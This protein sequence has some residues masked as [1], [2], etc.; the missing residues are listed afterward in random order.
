MAV[1]RNTEL[2]GKTAIVTGSARNIGRSIALELASA[3]ARVV[4]NGRTDAAAAEAVAGE[5]NAAGGAAVACIADITIEA[6]VARLVATSI[7]E[8]GGLDI[9][10]NNAAL[11]T[12]RDFATMTYDDWVETREVA[13]D[14][15]VRVSLACVPHLIARGGGCSVVGIGGLMATMAAPGGAHKSAVKDGMGGL[16]RGMAVDLGKHDITCNVAVVGDIATDRASGSGERVGGAKPK[17]PLG[18][19]GEPQDIA[20]LVRFLVGPYARYIS[21]QT[22]HVNGGSFRPHSG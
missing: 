16:I 10:V 4:I 6:D 22:I 7:S 14:G 21:G 5:I 18:R 9:L 19:T 17:V 12:K 3:G 20:D 8:F 15:T 11:R 13:L 1:D 2:A